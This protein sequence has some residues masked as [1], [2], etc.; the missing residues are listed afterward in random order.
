M[1]Y[2]RNKMK[3]WAR[4]NGG[5]LWVWPPTDSRVKVKNLGTHWWIEYPNP[6]DAPV[7]VLGIAIIEQHPG[8]WE[9]Q[10]DDYVGD[11]YNSPH[12]AWI[13]WLDDK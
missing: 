7:E 6:I 13:G 10:Q 12:A 1:G 8:Q 5:N 3:R 4:Q 2:V 11:G 9:W